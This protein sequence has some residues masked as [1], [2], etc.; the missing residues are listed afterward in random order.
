MFVLQS[1]LTAT[2]RS[3]QTSLKHA[4]GWRPVIMVGGAPASYTLISLEM[5]R[6]HPFSSPSHASSRNGSVSITRR[7]VD[8]M[9]HD[10][11]TTSAHWADHSPHRTETVIVWSRGEARQGLYLLSTYPSDRYGVREPPRLSGGYPH[12]GYDGG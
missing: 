9:C 10:T 6:Q 8:S 1:S 7:P 2:N 4:Y 3:V 12:A 11:A 5:V